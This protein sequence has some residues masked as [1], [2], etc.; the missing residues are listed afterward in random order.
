MSTWKKVVLVNAGGLIGVVIS[1]F[2]VSPQTPLWLWGVLSA[3]AIAGLN[4]F[5]F[6]WRRTATS[7]AKNGVTSA[8]VIG[9]GLVVLLLDLL[10]RH[11]H[12]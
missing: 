3:A 8:I 12:R 2:I 10:L 4:Y 11:V 7:G 5:C 6:G 1:L 9:V